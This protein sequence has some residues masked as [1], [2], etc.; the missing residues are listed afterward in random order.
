MKSGQ[1]IDVE[2]LNYD[3][4]FALFTCELVISGGSLVSFC[5]EMLFSLSGGL[6]PLHAAVM[7]HNSVVKELRHLENPCL[8]MTKE[9]VQRK[10]TYVEC[11]KILLFMGASIG[12]KVTVETL[13]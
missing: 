6:T 4:K 2:M 11:I 1:P 7:S 13:T 9:M 10:Q 12:S 8:Y 3:G 5:N